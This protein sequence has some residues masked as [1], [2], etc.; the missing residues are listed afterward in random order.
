MSDELY[1]SGGLLVV[2]I[3]APAAEGTDRARWQFTGLSDGQATLNRDQV[4]QLVLTLA[5]SINLRP[6]SGRFPPALNDR[7]VADPFSLAE[8]KTLRA[9]WSGEYDELTVAELRERFK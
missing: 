4:R 2:A 1:D 5:R 7:V 9:L 3:A 8:L 6:T